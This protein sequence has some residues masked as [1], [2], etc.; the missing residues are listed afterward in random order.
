[1]SKKKTIKVPVD[2][3]VTKYGRGSVVARAAGLE[4]GGT[5]EA[6]AA[7]SLA[8]R[9]RIALAGRPIDVLRVAVAETDVHVLVAR[10]G[11][12]EMRTYDTSNGPASHGSRVDMQFD[13]ADAP[14]ASAVRAFDRTSATLRAAKRGQSALG[15]A[16]DDPA[17]L[18]RVVAQAADVDAAGESVDVAQRIVVE[19]GRLRRRAEDA[20]RRALLLDFGDAS[21]TTPPPEVAAFARLL[22]LRPGDAATRA[23]ALAVL[24]DSAGERWSHDLRALRSMTAERGLLAAVD[25]ATHDLELIDEAG[26]DD[27][28][29]ALAAVKEADESEFKYADWKAVEKDVVDQ[30]WDTKG[31]VDTEIAR[32][33]EDDDLGGAAGKAL[34]KRVALEVKAA[35]D[36]AK[37]DAASTSNDADDF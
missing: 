15:I 12:V 13:P 31:P 1:M 11:S 21:A 4:V 28:D 26:Y 37:E 7:A 3:T 32:L 35:L 18:L 25:S 27:V 2:A 5:T 20:E 19:F 30:T 33:I 34:E 16:A 22:G 14:P 10:L 17:S 36:A 8:D 9:L 24:E 6:E 23:E 29:E